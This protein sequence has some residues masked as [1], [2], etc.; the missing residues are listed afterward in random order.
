[1]LTAARQLARMRLG[2]LSFR[3]L[4]LLASLAIAT[5]AWLL[6]SAF[7]ARFSADTARQFDS[8][9]V[10][11]ESTSQRMPLSYVEKIRALSGVK[12][13]SH[14]NIFPLGCKEKTFVTV[15]AWN[16][17][18]DTPS[19]VNGI[20]AGQISILMQDE[21]NI[22]IGEAI[23]DRCNWQTGTHL[24]PYESF[25]SKAV[26]PVYIA[27]KLAT[28][29]D[30]D[31]G[32]SGLAAF[33]NYDYFNRFLPEPDQNRA[34]L[35]NVT[36]H[37]PA[38]L[39]AIANRIEA[40]LA[41]EAV[42]VTASTSAN[43]E[44]T[45]ARFGNIRSLLWLVSGAI[46]ACTLLVFISTFAHVAAERRSSTA[47]LKGLGFRF[48]TL[49][50]GFTIE[51]VL[52]LLSGVLTGAIA[53]LGLLHWLAPQVQTYIGQIAIPASSWLGLGIGVIALGIVSAIFPVY[54]LHRSHPRER[55][56]M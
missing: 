52:I 21:K 36:A 9:T 18:P 3:A 8:I 10:M 30:D 23:A 39:P 56:G 38:E 14:M 25:F 27:G 2:E 45:L 54:A 28:R 26:I 6:L 17:S 49:L 50:A 55:D 53:S 48:D 31:S 42:P 12:S 43:A 24:E 19:P 7:A 51:L 5:L 32:F 22:F 37:N 4:Y 33:G 41:S 11:P 35:I 44:N 29:K 1:M 15:N 34:Q 13:V 47:T 16:F 40:L 20:D 46:S